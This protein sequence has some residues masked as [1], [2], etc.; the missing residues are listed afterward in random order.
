MNCFIFYEFNNLGKVNLPLISSL[1]LDEFLAFSEFF[2]TID[3]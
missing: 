2:Y 3:K 1:T